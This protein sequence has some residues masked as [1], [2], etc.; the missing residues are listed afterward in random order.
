MLRRDAKRRVAQL[1]KTIDALDRLSFCESAPR[2]LRE[3]AHKTVVR[4]AIVRA[5]LLQRIVNETPRP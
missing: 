5:I 3:A 2:R 1:K 4:A